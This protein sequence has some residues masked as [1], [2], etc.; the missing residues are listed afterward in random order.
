MFL[1]IGCTYWGKGVCPEEGITLI[2]KAI[3]LN[4]IP[5]DHYLNFLGNTYS[6][7][8]RYEDAIEVFEVVL[9]RSPNNLGTHLM[10][11]A[12]YSG[13]GREEEARQQAKE[14]LR[15]DPTFSL[16]QYAEIPWI[17]DEAEAER[18]I[19]LLRKA[20]LK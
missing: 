17:K 7:L 4:P 15:L 12:A 18:F 5:P 20:G 2:E 14:L 6:F 9:K 13:S 16:E 3:R 1:K 8:R 11:T 10:L 19:D